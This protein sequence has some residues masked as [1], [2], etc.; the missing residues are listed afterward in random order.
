MSILENISDEMLVNEFVKRIYDEHHILKN[1]LKEAEY[2]INRYLKISKEHENTL[3]VIEEYVKKYN[4]IE[5]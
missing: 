1:R 2:I 4:P 3:E 5:K